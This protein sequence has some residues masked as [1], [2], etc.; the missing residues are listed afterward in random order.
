M[1]DAS[2]FPY[3]ENIKLTKKVVQYARKHNVTV[4]AELARLK[5]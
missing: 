5:V 3:E 4:E 2:S 1:I